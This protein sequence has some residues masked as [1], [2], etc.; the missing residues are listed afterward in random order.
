MNQILDLY[1]D[2][3]IS[4]TSYT[5]ATGLSRVTDNRISH[6]KVTR[7]LSRRE[8]TSSDLWGIAKSI[9]K[10]VER[11]D[12]VLV[13][14]DS[15]E[16]KPYTDENELISWHFDH[17]EKRS[18]KGIN[19]ITA[20]YQSGNCS[21]P[22]G[23]ELVRKTK[24]IT[25]SKTGREQRKAPVSKNE[26]FRNLLIQAVHNKL[27]FKYVLADSWFASTKNM[28]F[29]KHEAKKEFIMPLKSN[30]LVALSEKDKAE[31]K[32]VR[33]DSVE[34]G[35]NILVWPKGV[36]I[37]LR[38]SRQV[39]KDG[40]G[41][42]GILYLVS[43]DIEL[44]NEQISTIY[45]KRW[46]VEV[47]HQSLKGNASLEKSP[48]K[49]PRTQANHFFASLCAYIRLECVSHMTKLN[50]TALKNKIYTDRSYAS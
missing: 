21:A 16:K 41:V 7:F 45:K 39:F 9:C 29:I 15:I 20:L 2:Y 35:E 11:E 33:I 24:K 12:A 32:F 3:L 49:T 50:H 5:T 6:D 36:E 27:K 26:H 28:H 14:D 25:N 18:V 43:S 22:V 1:V 37:A 13:F 34:P 46:K 10:S 4:S 17:A 44:T 47:Y 8:F 31:G 23:Y 38:F 48:A 30:R 40:D 42:T 19:F